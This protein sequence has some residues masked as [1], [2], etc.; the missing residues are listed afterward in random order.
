MCAPLCRGCCC[1]LCPCVRLCPGHSVGHDSSS[2]SSTPSSSS[3][4]SSSGRAAAATMNWGL[5]QQSQHGGGHGW[6][7]SLRRS[8]KNKGKQHSG[9][10]PGPPG[11]DQRRARSAWD[12]SRNH[13]LSSSRMVGTGPTGQARRAETAETGFYL[14]KAQGS[15]PC[16]GSFPLDGPLAP[17]GQW[18]IQGRP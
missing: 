13:T 17:L 4:S 10:G 15:P 6:F 12:L 5:S 2:R 18:R 8:R 3:T 7:S 1:G 14:G 16:T 9:P 11:F